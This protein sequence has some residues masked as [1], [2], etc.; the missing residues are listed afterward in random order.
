MYREKRMNY[1]NKTAKI[2]KIEWAARSSD[3]NIIENVESMLSDIVYDGP[4]P[5]NLKELEQRILD[6]VS[7]IKI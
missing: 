3:L 1:I 4:K 5:I 7:T 6:S 2:Q